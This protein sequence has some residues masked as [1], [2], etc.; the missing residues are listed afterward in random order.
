MRKDNGERQAARHARLSGAHWNTP[1][2]TSR[3][4]ASSGLVAAIAGGSSAA[5]PPGDLPLIPE[6]S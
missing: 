5:A 6:V 2:A 4:P 3:P 1:A